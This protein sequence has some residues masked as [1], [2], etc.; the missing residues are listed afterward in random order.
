MKEEKKSPIKDKPLRYPGQSLDQQRED[1]AYDKVLGPILAAG[2]ML[3]F[4][5]MEWL[6]YFFPLPPQPWLIS[7]MAVLAVFYAGWKIWRL[8]P[9]ARQ[10]RQASEGEKA[11]GQ[12]LEHLRGDGYSVFHDVLGEGFNVDHILIG[13][14]GLFTVET[15]TIS[16]PVRGQPKI[17][18]DGAS[19]LVNGMEPDRNPVIQAKAQA[20]WLKGVLSESTGK[21]FPV[22][23]VVVYPGWFIEQ[24]PGSTR[25]LWVLEPKAL[26]KF[27]AKESKSLSAEEVKIASFHLSQFIR[28][29]ERAR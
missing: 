2:L 20:S 1:L 8:F 15:K 24:S 23:P 18:F 9:I 16:K 26:P 12:F 7:F 3:I 21:Q 22:R 5:A 10:L 4:A 13:P 19:I 27:L 14:A 28:A 25:E 11:V 17:T 29:G 6:R